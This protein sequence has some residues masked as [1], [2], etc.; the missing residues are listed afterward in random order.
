MP[1]A[2]AE[3]SEWAAPQSARTPNIWNPLPS[4]TDVREL[5]NV[6]DTTLFFRDIASGML[7]SVVWLAPSNRYSEHPRGK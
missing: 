6:K 7:P 2:M 4:F 5:N 3:G 1:D